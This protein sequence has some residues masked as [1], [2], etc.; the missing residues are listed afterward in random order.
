MSTKP[1]LFTSWFTTLAAKRIEFIN[2]ESSP[3][4]YLNDD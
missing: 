1:A 3:E 4:V 2:L